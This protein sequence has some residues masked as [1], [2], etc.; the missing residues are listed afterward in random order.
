M[1]DA[2]S[3]KYKIYAAL[4]FDVG[5]GGIPVLYYAVLIRTTTK[6]RP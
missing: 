3:N 5:G 6:L 1:N 2:R 4:L